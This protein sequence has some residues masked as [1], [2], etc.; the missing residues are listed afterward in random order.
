MA[1]GVYRIPISEAD[2]PKI[3]AHTVGYDDAE[4]LMM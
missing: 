2:L 3:P 4:Q 1:D